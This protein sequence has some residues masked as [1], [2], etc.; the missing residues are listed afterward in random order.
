MVVFV[1]AYFLIPRGNIVP[2]LIF[3]LQE[4]LSGAGYWPEFDVLSP[5]NQEQNLLKHCALDLECLCES[6]E[7]RAEA[8]SL[9]LPIGR[10]RLEELHHSVV[11]STSS[12][13]VETLD[14]LQR[15]QD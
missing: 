5:S 6:C 10:Y 1:A 7:E 2:G 3:D 4:S 14:R 15:L 12:T 9:G 11:F 8:C 13:Q